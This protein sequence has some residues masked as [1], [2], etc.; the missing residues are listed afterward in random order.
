MEQKLVINIFGGPGV[1]KSTIA[2]GLFYRMKC[3]HYDVE[4]IEEYAKHLVYQNRLNVLQKDQLTILSKQHSKL[5]DVLETRSI[6]IVDSPLLLSRI[7]F[8]KDLNI[9]DPFLFGP[10]VIQLFNA[11]PNFNIYLERNPD[12]PYET[13]GRVQETKEEAMEIDEKVKMFLKLNSI[14]Y[15][16]VMSSESAVEI[17]LNH[18][19]LDRNNFLEC[20]KI[21]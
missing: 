10:V 13:K 21:L 6:A 20:S 11:Y 19:I 4:L 5:R 2:A 8:N 3:Q 17:I 18:L 7:Y 15:V 14:P 16:K 12:L 9:V 1:G